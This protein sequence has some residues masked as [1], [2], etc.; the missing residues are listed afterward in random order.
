MVPTVIWRGRTHIESTATLHYV[1][2]TIAAERGE[3]GLSVA[4][5]AEGRI[6]YLQWSSLY[7]ETFEARLVEYYLSKNG[8]LPAAIAELT[9]ARLRKRLATLA[10]ELPAAGF[11]A[12]G[13]FTVAD[14]IASYMPAE[15]LRLEPLQVQTT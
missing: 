11:L 13:R 3:P 10:G 6:D 5:G 12:A 2:E 15:P 9:E 7:A 14:I 1:A 4:S 8:V